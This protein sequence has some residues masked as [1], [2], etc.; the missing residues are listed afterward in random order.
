MQNV[1][2][3]SIEPL[4]LSFTFESTPMSELTTV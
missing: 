3:K 4:L 2:C 1:K